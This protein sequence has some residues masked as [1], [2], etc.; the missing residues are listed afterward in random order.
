[1]NFTEVQ[2]GHLRRINGN[3][4]AQLGRSQLVSLMLIVPFT[5]AIQKL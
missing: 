1:L 4:G 3:H 5:Y 2:D